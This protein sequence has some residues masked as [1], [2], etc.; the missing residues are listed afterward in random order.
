MISNLLH[1]K[2]IPKNFIKLLAFSP[3]LHQNKT[4]H[5]N[6]NTL[7]FD[8][9]IDQILKEST[10]FLQTH[11]KERNAYPEILNTSSWLSKTQSLYLPSAAMIGADSPLIWYGGLIFWAYILQYI[12]RVVYI[13]MLR[14]P[15]SF[16]KFRGEWALVSGS[17][18]GIGKA[19][20]Y[21]LA[22]RGVNIVLLSRSTDKMHKI[23]KEL[24]EKYGVEARCI[25][26]DLLETETCFEKIKKELENAGIKPLVLVNNAG[27]G[28]PNEDLF[29]EYHYYSREQ[30]QQMFNLNVVSTLR[31]TRLCLPYMVDAKKGAI[32]NVS[33]LASFSSEYT[34]IYGYCK[35]LINN[36]S[37]SLAIEYKKHGI[38]VQACL[39]GRVDTPAVKDFTKGFDMISPEAF[40]EDSLNLFGAQSTVLIPNWRHACV[41]WLLH[42]ALPENLRRWLY[43]L[44]Q[45]H[46]KNAVLK[47]K[48]K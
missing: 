8:H 46:V 9:Q 36:F 40:A 31:L 19:F 42:S 6:F 48:S 47:K 10:K 30:E 25:T 43:R 18:Y 15:T 24:R 7:Q 20:C 14:P 12:L 35:A 45:L 28:G 21:S 32:L 27:G 34:S 41:N 5:D 23:A 17:S 2:N 4:S 29:Y 11:L 13:R 26:A 1:K 22:S 37:N 33:S 39:A 38:V 16:D 3:K 44:G